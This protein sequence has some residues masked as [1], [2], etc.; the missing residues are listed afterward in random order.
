MGFLLDTS[1]FLEAT[2]REPNPGVLA[3]LAA[4]DEDDA[5]ICVV[6]IAELRHYRETLLTETQRT[7]LELWVREGLCCRFAG[8]VLT[9][10]AEIAH[11]C[12]RISV[13][14]ESMCRP[15]ELRTALIAATAD[16]HGLTL[17]TRHG[18]DFESIVNDVLTP[19]TEP[20]KFKAKLNTRR[21]LAP[22]AKTRPA[23]R[24]SQVVLNDAQGARKR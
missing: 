22:W 20:A 5:F 10:D 24:I 8:R 4:I 9:I 12:R 3:W 21:G 7:N 23:S 16:V 13:L 11:A 18:L 6:T 17:V 15:L 2:E 14:S 1:V 19:W